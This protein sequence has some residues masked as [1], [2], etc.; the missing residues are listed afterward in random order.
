MDEKTAVRTLERLVAH[1]AEP[2]DVP[3]FRELHSRS[4]ARR[5]KALNRAA[6][7][8]V[9]VIGVVGVLGAAALVR[10]ET[11]SVVASGSNEGTPAE[12]E[13]GVDNGQALVDD[14]LFLEALFEGIPPQEQSGVAAFSANRERLF[15]LVDSSGG[16]STLSGPGSG[17]VF[18]L[19][20]FEVDGLEQPLFVWA[21]E[22][23]QVVEGVAGPTVAPRCPNPHVSEIT[24]DATTGSLS[25]RLGAPELLQ[26]PTFPIGCTDSPEVEFRRFFE[27]DFHLQPLPDQNFRLEGSDGRFAVVSAIEDREQLGDELITGFVN[28]ED[29]AI[30]QTE[31]P[32]DP[33]EIWAWLSNNSTNDQHVEVR[34]VV[35]D[36]ESEFSGTEVLLTQ[37]LDRQDAVI[38]RV[39][40][41]CGMTVLIGTLAFDE[42]G[43][44][45]LHDNLRLGGRLSSRA[46]QDC[47]RE[48]PV[49]F[50]E[51]F[52]EPFTIEVGQEGAGFLTTSQTLELE[53]NPAN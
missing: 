50:Q 6:G 11:P 9:A 26:R 33:S 21:G 47:E 40:A 12:S 31:E 52:T 29:L 18:S 3:D 2:V 13:T 4:K 38:M 23:L 36:E 14:V 43:E 53:L 46:V 44:A 7:L 27:S 48:T 22:A 34:L 25:F 19:K 49:E 37:T 20:E 24:Q 30:E 45:V 1:V 15:E 39:F 8:A 32:S 5:R 16:L 41:D 17:V 10:S 35:Q 42:S 28:S 51:L